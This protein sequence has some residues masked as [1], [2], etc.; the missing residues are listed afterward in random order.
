MPPFAQKFQDLEVWKKAFSVSIDVHKA[1][2]A[3]PDI[4]RFAMADQM[5]R[6]SKS[7]CANIAE[8]FAK[9]GQSK[10]EFRRFLQMAMAS[11]NEM[12]VWIIYAQELEYLSKQTYDLWHTEYTSI[13]K[14]LNSLHSKT[15]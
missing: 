1:I 13:C 6:A 12:L 8:G 4:E 14:M 15:V 10:R 11:A 2:L 7:V 5:R 3:F 9:Q